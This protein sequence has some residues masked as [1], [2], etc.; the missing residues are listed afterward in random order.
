MVL[1]YDA[2]RHS[3][4]HRPVPVDQRSEGGL[5]AGRGEASKEFGVRSG[6]R[7]GQP[8]ANVG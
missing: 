3:E 4:H 8:T 6:A 2:P 5:I 1:S 7:V